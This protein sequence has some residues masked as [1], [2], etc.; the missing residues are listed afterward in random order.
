MARRAF[1]VIDIGEILVHWHAGRSKKLWPTWNRVA[2]YSASLART[3]RIF[4]RGIAQAVASRRKPSQD[5]RASRAVTDRRRLPLVVAVAVTTRP[6]D[7]KRRGRATH[8]EGVPVRCS[9][10]Q[11]PHLLQIQRVPP[12][13]MVS[14]VGPQ[15]HSACRASRKALLA[16]SPHLAPLAPGCPLA[17][18]P[19]PRKLRKPRKPSDPGILSEFLPAQPG[20]Q[21]GAS[22]RSHVLAHVDPGDPLV[23]H[24]HQL[25]RLLQR[26]ISHHG[27]DAPPAGAPRSVQETHTHAHAATTGGTRHGAPASDFS[28]ASSGPKRTG[29]GRQ[30]AAS[31][32]AAPHDPVS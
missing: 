21:R 8:Y 5:I 26:L 7:R 6:E 1:D 28:T 2:G 29:D 17:V 23:H 10:V 25:V 31:S 18:S 20:I 22:R 11:R 15:D 4:R 19:R 12:L 14:A 9:Q 24:S 27:E 3:V 13:I 16:P 32:M 30:H